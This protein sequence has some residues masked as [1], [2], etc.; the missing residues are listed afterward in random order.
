MD[1]KRKR[2]RERSALLVGSIG[3]WVL[4]P[5]SLL[6]LA[7]WIDTALPLPRISR[8]VGLG[9]GIPLVSSAL[10]CACWCLVTFYLRGGGFPLAFLPPRRLVREGPYAL[11]RHPLYLSF[12]LYLIGLGLLLRSVAAAGIVIPGVA[13]L[14]ILY[15]RFHEEPVIARRY[16][17]SYAEYKA[18]VPFFFRLRRGIPGPGVVFSLVYLVGK[19]IVRVFFPIEVT[20][21]EHLPQSG[22]YIILANHA[23]YLDPVLL[24]AASDRYIRFLTTGEMIRTRFG[25]W[26]FSRV[27]SIPTRRYR[28]DPASV[29]GLLAALKGGEI[30]G[31]FPEG[32]R[33][34]DG[35]PLPVDRTV[36]RLLRRAGVPLVTARIEGSYAIYPRWSG[37]PLPGRI[38]IRFFDGSSAA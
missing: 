25:R 17:A 38:N 12:T 4:L 1:L 34:W 20:G 13:A 23:S 2:L 16:G 30:A 35:N 21:E 31:I 37:Y 14:W 24:I 27:G 22:P 28:V 5:G 8:A 19:L 18:A 26:F 33:T 36:E 9:I 32:E 15:A 29:R 11:S 3:Y 6:P 7:R 10:I